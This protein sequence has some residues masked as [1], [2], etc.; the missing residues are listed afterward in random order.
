MVYSCNAPTK[1]ANDQASVSQKQDFSIL[2]AVQTEWFGGRE[3]V[4]GRHYKIV[5]KKKDSQS[6]LFKSLMINGTKVAVTTKTE[7]K[8]IVLT[9][10]M[11]DQRRE[12]TIDASSGQEIPNQDLTVQASK[13]WL[14]YTTGTSKAIK[15]L[16]IPKFTVSENQEFYP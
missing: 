3:G 15:K 16:I 5:L 4:K 14:E 9:A 12:P 7:G 1:A 6:Y 8:L 11:T 2:S 10:S 13:Y